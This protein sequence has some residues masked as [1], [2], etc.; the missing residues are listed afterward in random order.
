VCPLLLYNL[1]GYTVASDRAV[2]DRLP[3]ATGDP[4]LTLTWSDG[5]PPGER[6]ADAPCLYVSPF[7]NEDGASMLR[8]RQ[9]DDSHILHFPGVADFRVEDRRIECRL[10]DPRRLYLAKIYLLGTVF[11]LWLERRGTPALHA[12]AVVLPAGAAAFLSDTGAGKSAL[13]MSFV[14]A[15]Y[16]LLTD[17]ILP[18]EPAEGGYLG[19]PGYPLM[20]LW[21]DQADHFLGAHQELERV[22]PGGEKRRVGMEEAV[23]AFVGRPERLARLYLPVR[24]DTADTDPAIAIVKVPP[25]EAV[26]E[27]VRNLFAVRI[28]HALGWHTDRLRF[29]ASLVSHVPVRRLLYPTGFEHLAA[30]REAI[31]QDCQSPIPN[32]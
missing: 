6:A 9:Q 8:V 26:F 11:S 28:V 12:S 15:G 1:Y 27:L 16:P 31:L 19:R 13:A 23:G 24:R 21:P 22:E 14:R 20:R 10:L 29:F 25:S 4:N 18:V 32:P 2:D 7:L 5:H 17:D 3:H 30:V